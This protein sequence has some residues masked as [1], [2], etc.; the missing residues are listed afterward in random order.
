MVGEQLGLKCKQN[1]KMAVSINGNVG[2]NP[3][4]MHNPFKNLKFLRNKIPSAAPYEFADGWKLAK[5]SE[6]IHVQNFNG[7]TSLQTLWTEN[8]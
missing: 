6:S 7:G 8:D 5:T 2:G 4:Y 1:E 3:L